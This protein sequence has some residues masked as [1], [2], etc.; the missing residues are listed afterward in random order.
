[1]LKSIEIMIRQMPV[2][3]IALIQG[4]DDC[5]IEYLISVWFVRERIAYILAGFFKICISPFIN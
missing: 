2:A 1:M 3:L 4:A 5:D